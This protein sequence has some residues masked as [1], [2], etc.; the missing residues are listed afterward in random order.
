M[1]PLAGCFFA[2]VMGAAGG[3]LFTSWWW[4]REFADIRRRAGLAR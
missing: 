4:R 2:F 3:S 1:I